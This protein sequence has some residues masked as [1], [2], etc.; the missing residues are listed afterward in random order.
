MGFYLFVQISS[1]NVTNFGLFRSHH[2]FARS[3]LQ[4]SFSLM[5]SKPA[6]DLN[7][8]PVMNDKQ[9]A[10]LDSIAD[11]QVVEEDFSS[12]AAAPAVPVELSKKERRFFNLFKSTNTH[13]NDQGSIPK[14]IDM[15]AVHAQQASSSLPQVAMSTAEIEAKEEDMARR[16]AYIAEYAKQEQKNAKKHDEEHEHFVNIF[17][18]AKEQR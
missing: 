15:N 4:K 1:Q 2:I 16:Q 18:S 13:E 9:A 14:S 3:L 17:K 7:V 11:E 8:N 5:P 10:M 12:A 6:Q